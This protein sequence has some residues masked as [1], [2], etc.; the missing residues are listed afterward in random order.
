MYAHAYSYLVVVI[1]LISAR[2]QLSLSCT[3]LI[4]EKFSRE[5]SVIYYLL[6]SYLNNLHTPHLSAGMP[7]YTRVSA[8]GSLNYNPT[9]LKAPV[10][11]HLG[12]FVWSLTKTLFFFYFNASKIAF[13]SIVSYLKNTCVHTSPIGLRAVTALIDFVT[14]CLLAVT[15]LS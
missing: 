13:V 4:Y 2:L 7:V 12:Q 8:M 14:P 5:L 6:S 11:R 15:A 10:H 9:L 1:Q 3:S